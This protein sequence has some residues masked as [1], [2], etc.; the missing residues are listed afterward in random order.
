M[1]QPVPRCH[2]GFSWLQIRNRL[3]SS[4]CPGAVF[5]EAPDR[6]FQDSC[7]GYPFQSGGFQ[8]RAVPEPQRV[9]GHAGQ[10]GAVHGCGLSIQ[11]AAKPAPLAGIWPDHGGLLGGCAAVVLA[12]G[13]ARFVVSA[14]AAG[15]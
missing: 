4:Y 12:G 10:S 9:A 13:H 14:G 15:H 3:R 1:T 6:V 2:T 7:R 5:R 11:T 8:Y